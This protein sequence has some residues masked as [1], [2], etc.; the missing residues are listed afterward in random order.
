MLV[1]I[2]ALSVAVRLAHLWFVYATPSFTH[3]RT[4]PVSDMYILNTW[5]GRS[6]T[7]ISWT[8][9]APPAARL[10]ARRCAAERWAAWLGEAPA[11]L[12]A[13]FYAYLLA[14]LRWLFGD[15]M[16]PVVILQIAAAGGA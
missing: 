10:D 16:L 14:L 6:S 3:H 7:G 15:A 5:P 8:R 1:A 12:K 2:V 4:W 13:P 11:F 9:P